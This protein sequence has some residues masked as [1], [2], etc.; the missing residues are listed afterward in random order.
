M[1]SVSASAE[2]ASTTAPISP[3]TIPVGLG[4][5]CGRY[6][7]AAVLTP[8]PSRSVG[9]GLRRRLGVLLDITP[10]VASSRLVHLYAERGSPKYERAPMRWLRR[11]L[12]KHEPRARGCRPTTGVDACARA[13]H[14]NRPRRV[15]SATYRGVTDTTLLGP[16]TSPAVACRRTRRR[17]TFRVGANAN[18]MRER[19]SNCTRA[20]GTQS[21]RSREYAST[22]AGIPGCGGDATPSSTARRP[23]CRTRSAIIG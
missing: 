14:R 23:T 19:V 10:G 1:P 20:N 18:R 12:S 22:T 16:P 3:T 7:P 15:A 17:A 11:Y 4:S 5:M 9:K 6:P 21:N 13:L 8:R 2:T